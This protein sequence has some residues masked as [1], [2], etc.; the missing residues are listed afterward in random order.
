MDKQ[1][2]VLAIA[3]SLR[4]QSYNRALLGAAQRLAP[5]EMQIEIF[6]I[7][8]IPLFNQDE[9]SSL[10]GSVVEF[11]KKIREADGILIATP[12][13]N[14]SFPGVLKNAMDWAS[15]PQGDNAFNDKPVAIMGATLYA[16][17]SSRAQYQLRQTCVFLNMHQLNKPEVMVPFVAE[18]FNAGGELTDEYTKGKLTEFMEAFSAW[19]K[20]IKGE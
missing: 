18:K 2:H 10:P 11:K 19:I 17:G 15:R 4:K 20:R 13:Y 3:G 9:E 14:Y 8:S 16:L 12:E 6:D 5:E 1:L 7:A